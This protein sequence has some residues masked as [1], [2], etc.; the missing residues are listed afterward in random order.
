[1]FTT[2]AEAADVLRSLGAAG[3]AVRPVGSASRAGW[4]GSS[5]GDDLPTTGLN[6]ILEHNPGDFTAVLECGVPLADAQKT[7][8][9]AGQWLAL[10]PSPGGTI[11][12]LV[13]TADSGPARHR[14][15]GVRDLVIGVTL[16]LSD[17]TVAR[18]GGKVIKNV[19]GYD[20]G[21]LFT[22][23][24]GT[25][26][27]VAEVAVRL[28]PL[29][30]GTATAV[31][32][33]TDPSAVARAAAGL[34]RRPL[35]ALS[36]DATWRTGTGQLLVRFGGVTATSQ[37]TRVASLLADAPDVT[38]VENDEPLW[39]AQRAAQRSPSGAVL[40]VSHRPADLAAVLSAADAVGATVVSRA[41][42]GLS[43]LARP[44][45]RP[46]DVAT[47]RRL[48]APAPV[49]VLDGG[50]R[51]PAPWPDVD[52]GVVAVQQRVKARF[53][54]ARIFRPGAF[55]GGL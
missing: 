3:T 32:T 53:D 27:L 1:M 51:V 13:A 19:A 14:Y 35:E 44:D 15:G 28:H 8:A 26:G 12:G 6:R 54:P 41:A 55:V 23:S 31:A 17:G 50:D 9:S 47:V 42:L 52:A 36:L 16:V 5:G 20:L 43:W 7:F 25:L 46:D 33:F 38:V 49:T 18:S 30:T 37:A 21:K 48:L 29:P 4:G 39:D 2:V 34:S 10:D 22:G 11:G 45:V 24:F 40:K